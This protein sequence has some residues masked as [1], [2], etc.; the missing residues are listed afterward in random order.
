MERLICGAARRCITPPEELL[1]HLIGLKQHRFAGVIDDLYVRAVVLGSE[2]QRV[3]LVSFDMT[4]APCTE[5]FLRE[6]SAKT[7][8]EEDGILFFSI[9]TH[10]VPFNDIDLEER[11]AQSSQTLAV[12]R[13]YTQLLHEQTLAAAV[14]ACGRCVPARMGWAWGESAVNVVRLQEYTYYDEKGEPFPVCNLGADLRKPADRRLFALRVEDEA[15]APL[16]FLVNYPMHNVTTIWND[17]DGHGAMGVSGDVGGAVSRMLET[18][19]P[20][21]VAVWSSG[22]AGDLNPV[23][24]NETILPDPVTGRT[25][26]YCPKG[27]GMALT[28]LRT[29]SERHYADIKALLRTVR[30]AETDGKAAGAV[31]WSV[32]PGC[33]CIRHPGEPPE[34]V[35]GPDVPEHTVRVQ[36]VRVGGLTL[37]GAG[38][39]LYSSIGQTMLSAAPRDTVLI[40]HNASALCSSHYILDDETL[41]RC[42]AS[43][44]YAMVPGYDEYRCVAGVMGPDLA[45]CTDRLAKTIERKL[46]HEMHL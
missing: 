11:E 30:C 14:E 16:A 39:E 21:S 22:A 38:A 32:T 42:D 5:D 1:P 27:L 46:D 3:L 18:E 7:G 25:Y 20:G 6:L 33:D 31:T 10:A 40:T 41:A 37:L 26:E 17:F 36:M 45:K 28:C 24:L 34:F 4:T 19:N 9:H 35:T 44:G 15:G 29:V 2:R 13:A 43:R 23:M 8:V 12:C